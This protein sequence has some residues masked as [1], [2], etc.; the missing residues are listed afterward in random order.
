MLAVIDVD[1]GEVKTLQVL[2][3]EQMCARYQVK[4]V[5]IYRLMRLE[6]LPGCRFGGRLR[7]DLAEVEAWRKESTA[8]FVARMT[9][10]KRRAARQASATAAA[11][12]NEQP[13]RLK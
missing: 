5:T 10:H 4:K 12:K 9:S 2:T 11:N 1:P 8:R 3:L 7:F 6:G 13:G